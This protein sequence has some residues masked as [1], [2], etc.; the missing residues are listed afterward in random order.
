M[1]GI[2]VTGAGG[3]VGQSIIK[4]LQDS[5]YT[6]VA[7]DGEI[8][9]TGLFAVNRSYRIP[10]ARASDFTSRLLQICR[11]EG[12]RLL[13]P[14][15][16]AEL[17][18]LAEAREDF[19]AAGTTVVVSTPQ[20]VALADDKLATARFVAGVGLPAPWTYPLTEV[21][22]PLSFPV[23]LKPRHGGARS[24]GVFVAADEAQYGRLLESVERERYVAQEWVEGDEYTCGTV[25]LAARVLGPIVMRRVL[26][27]GDTYRAF[28]AQDSRIEEG[29]RHLVESL[30]PFGACNVQLRLRGGR[31]CVF[32]IN[33]R[34]SG[35]TY[36]RAL[37]GFNEPRMIADYLL[38][39]MEPQYVIREIAVLRYWK[40]LVVDAAEIE[41]LRTAGRRVGRERR[42]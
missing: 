30:Q 26:R 14:G 22:R 27:D 12:C 8:L 1:P 36:A 6:L 5:A 20:V 13:F 33:A 29:V 35:T 23:V 18:P 21:E 25:C 31:P 10:Y 3:G 32:E 41:D 2:L 40:E 34:C 17:G 4:A 42:L 38:G 24:Q 19:Q 7:A 11:D 9:A 39:G 28:V 15:L 16:D 37:A